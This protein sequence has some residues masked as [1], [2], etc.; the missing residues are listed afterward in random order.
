LPKAFFPKKGHKLKFRFATV[1]AIAR[2]P[3]VDFEDKGT[4]RRIEL[5]DAVVSS[6]R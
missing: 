4:F 3:E 6:S 5:V 2:M 1:P